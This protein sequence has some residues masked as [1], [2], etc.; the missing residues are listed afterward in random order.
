MPIRY[1]KS[2]K[3]RTPNGC[4]KPIDVSYGSGGLLPG[5][6]MMIAAVA[7]PPS[8]IRTT[9]SNYQESVKHVGRFGFYPGK[10]N[11]IVLTYH[12]VL[13]Q[14]LRREM[15]AA[16]DAR[17]QQLFYL[18]DMRKA[19]DLFRKE[20]RLKKAYGTFGGRNV[21]VGWTCSKKKVRKWFRRNLNKLLG[22]ET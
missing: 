4:F 6:F 12:D 7:K 20:V 15:A 10:E 18:I 14:L 16:S 19:E 13:L 1:A 2:R 3:S 17:R 22:K 8:R 9:V 5:Q 21:E 11:Y